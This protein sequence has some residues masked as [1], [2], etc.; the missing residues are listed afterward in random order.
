MSTVMRAVMRAVY[1]VVCLL[2]LWIHVVIYDLGYID[3]VDL[4]GVSL[5]YT[6]VIYQAIKI[7]E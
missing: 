1:S 2:I 4:F 6:F 5:V 7:K 3:R